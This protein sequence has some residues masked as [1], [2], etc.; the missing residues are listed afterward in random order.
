MNTTLSNR[1]NLFTRKKTSNLVIEADM[2][3][4]DFQVE[5]AI[6][7]QAELAKYK[8]EIDRYATHAKALIIGCDETD[9]EAVSLAGEM[10]KLY[11]RIESV[12]E[13]IIKPAKDFVKKVNLLAGGYTDQLDECARLLAAKSGAYKAQL[14]AKQEAELAEQAAI[15]EALGLTQTA[16]V[17]IEEVTASTKTEHGSTYQLTSWQIEVTDISKVP[18]QY[19][20]VNEKAVKAALKAGVNEIPGIKATEIKTTHLRAI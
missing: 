14:I 20:M 4:E 19:L 3:D 5:N 10:R 13:E 15:M 11:K 1:S 18:A 2:A 17:Q 7:F 6:N 9:R 16:P 8:R 12:R